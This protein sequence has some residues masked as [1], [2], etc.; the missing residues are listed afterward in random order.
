MS[1]WVIVAGILTLLVAVLQKCAPP[2]ALDEVVE[3]CLDRMSPILLVSR[4]TSDVLAVRW[5]EVLRRRAFHCHFRE[6]Q[7]VCAVARRFEALPDDIVLTTFPKT[8]TTLLQQLT[9]QIRSKGDMSFRDIHDV[10]PFV[11]INAAYKA[12]A[13]DVEQLSP[14]LFKVHQPLSVY[15]GGC[16]IFNNARDP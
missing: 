14:R 6:S 13:R 12:D 5:E 1:R 9:H 3:L 16:G 15:S 7:Q 8:G 4:A 2:N 10:V 11:E